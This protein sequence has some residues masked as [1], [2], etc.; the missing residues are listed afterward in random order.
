MTNTAAADIRAQLTELGFIPPGSPI[1][2]GQS[3]FD[4]RILDSLRL[5]ELVTRLE[6][7]F[8]IRVGQDDL[9]PD[10]FDSIAEM[11]RYIGEQL[12]NRAS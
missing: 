6:A 1:G 9:T 2:D 10:N 7:K 12:G 5:M 8:G 11:S 4:A 3:L